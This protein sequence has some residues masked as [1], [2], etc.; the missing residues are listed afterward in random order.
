VITQEAIESNSAAKIQNYHLSQLFYA[1]NFVFPWPTPK[2]GMYERRWYRPIDLAFKKRNFR[3]AQPHYLFLSPKA[4]C[5]IWVWKPCSCWHKIDIVTT[6]IWLFYIHWQLQWRRKV[7]AGPDSKSRPPPLPR[8]WVRL[9]PSPHSYGSA[10]T[11]HIATQL[12]PTHV[13]V[14]KCTP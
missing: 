5:C 10:C 13:F 12:L 7:W 9:P 3:T 4:S 14:W 8:P 2:L 6:K 11:A 1:S